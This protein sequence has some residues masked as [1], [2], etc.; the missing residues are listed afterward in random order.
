MAAEAF[1]QSRTTAG[2][3]IQAMAEKRRSLPDP[4]PLNQAAPQR[5]VEP[6]QPTNSSSNA[7]PVPDLTEKYGIWLK[8][9]SQ[10]RRETTFEG[11]WP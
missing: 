2:A 1:G 5:A 11:R 3:I 6:L 10:A 7:L 4:F 9:P 8:Q